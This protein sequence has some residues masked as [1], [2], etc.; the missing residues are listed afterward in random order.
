[1]SLDKLVDS[2]QL[3]TDLT[4]VANAIRA[5]SGGSSQLT[6]PAGFVSEIQSIVSGG[7]AN[8]TLLASGTYTVTSAQSSITIATGVATTAKTTK[9]LVVGD[10]TS[11]SS[12]FMKYFSVVYIDG[13]QTLK[14]T[15]STNFPKCRYYN[16]S[17]TGGGI[18]NYQSGSA[19]TTCC[20][21]SSNKEI[22]CRQWSANYKIQPATYSWY[23]WG[24]AAT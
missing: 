2:S 7:G 17:A 16:Q 18:V 6:F 22:V 13:P 11:A 9:A 15:A 3:D 10:L 24:E 19:S 21:I 4:S 1:M 20:Y 5:K 12:G 14:D 23:I 8:E